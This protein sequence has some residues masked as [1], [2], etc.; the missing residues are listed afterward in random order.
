MPE[1]VAPDPNLPEPT[2]GSRITRVIIGAPKDPRDP[3]AFHKISLIAILAWV[4]LG[5][6][7]LSSSAYGPAE[8]FKALGDHVGLAVFLALAMAVTVAVISSSEIRII[9]QFPAGGGGYAVASKFLGEPVGVLAGSALLIDY[10]LTIT[11]SL[12]SGA[13]TICSFLPEP[14]DDWKLAYALI[15]LGLLLVLN[16]RGVKESVTAIAPVFGLFLVT[17][18]LMF[19]A[20]IFGHIGDFADETRQVRENLGRSVSTL[21]MWGV[22]HLFARAYALGGG[23][24][25]GIEAVSNSVGL[26]RPPRVASA[27]ILGYLL[28]DAKPEPGKTM[29]A[30][31]FDRVAGSWRI[32]GFAIG[33]V[34]VI[35]TLI[36]EAAL[37]LIAAQ[38]GFIA[39]PRVMANLASDSW[40][41][42]RF[43]ALSDRLTMRNGVVLMGAAAAAALLHSWW[44]T[45][46]HEHGT[47]ADGGHATMVSTLVIMYAINVFVTFSLANVGMSRF[48]IKQRHRQPKW[49]RR[50]AVHLVA[51][52]L[53]GLILVVTIY[54]KF[55]EGAW[56]TVVVT[57]ALTLLCFGI[58]RHYG[59][60]V[61]AIRRLDQE[62]PGPEDLT[63]APDPIVVPMSL[64]EIDKKKPVAILFVGGYGGLGRHALLTCLRMFPGHFKGVVFMSVA[65]VDTGAFKGED[66]VEALIERTKDSLDA[67][68][69]FAASLGLPATS[70]FAVGTEVPDEAV[71]LGTQAIKDYPRGL[72][73]AGQLVFDADTLWTHMLHN[74]TAFLIQRRLQH[75][76]VPMIVVPVKLNLEA[77]R[78]D[79]PIVQRQRQV[80]ATD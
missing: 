40:F 34:F 69:R 37:L 45:R 4:G 32:G 38:A 49:K 35:I 5:A 15:G 67:Y 28:L 78:R 70:A 43:S 52:A 13:E 68:V 24:Y 62:L 7:G 77:T 50:L 10:V 59:L 18:A 23:T 75:I 48:W 22:L 79:H 12:A 16:L 36:S 31:L 58:K 46:G 56:V 53:C 9:E 74:E 17:H 80:P 14:W 64:G 19:G 29:N 73:V 1:P 66:E 27:I 42:H 47:D 26:M 30:V 25:T 20:I 63:P 61:R 54:E 57:L 71:R 6:D 8:A 21:G 44:S 39:G 33:E 2:L 76:G 51:A 41:P 3:G 72:V 55:L 60:V 65:V 11:I